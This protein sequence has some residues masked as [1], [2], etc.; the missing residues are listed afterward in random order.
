M[1]NR[2]IYSVILVSCLSGNTLVSA[3]D[4]VSGERRLYIYGTPDGCLVQL[5]SPVDADDKLRW[6]GPCTNEYASGEGTLT[7]LDKNGKQKKAYTGTM[8]RGEPL[9]RWNDGTIARK[10]EN[11]NIRNLEQPLAAPQGVSWPTIYFDNNSS[12]LSFQALKQLDDLIQKMNA[13]AND[14]KIS[15]SG[16]SSA[17]G[18]IDLNN[19]LSLFRA[20]VVRDYMV[21]KGI[22]RTR[23]KVFGK[24]TTV[25]IDQN[26]IADENRRVTFS[27]SSA[28][29]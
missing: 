24:G 7:I 4:R 10:T 8:D 5:P 13:M 9:G 15:V 25:P 29:P 1:N 19:K 23:I 11:D 14:L 17:S 22:D 28:K 20:M 2:L 26:G 12:R 3:N 18:S 16:H 6:K 27:V 21:A